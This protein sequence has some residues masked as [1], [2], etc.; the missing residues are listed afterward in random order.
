M[1]VLEIAL[2][3]PIGYEEI[4]CLISEIQ[5]CETCEYLIIDTGNH[6]FESVKIIKYFREQMQRIKT[7]LLN[8]IKIALI[9]PPEYKN[10]SNEPEMYNYFTSRSDAKDWFQ[11]SQIQN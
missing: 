9:H 4:D 11:H 10:E 1:D 6:E 5:T 8:Y 3:N 7:E 2:V